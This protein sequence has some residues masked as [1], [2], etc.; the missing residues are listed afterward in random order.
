MSRHQMMPSVKL[1]SGSSE[2]S[3]RKRSPKH[4]KNLLDTSL[5]KIETYSFEKI[6][7]PKNPLT[8]GAKSSN[9]SSVKGKR[10]T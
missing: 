9:S 5:N 3:F 7:S 1:M 8:E 4:S 6:S 10:A 2:F